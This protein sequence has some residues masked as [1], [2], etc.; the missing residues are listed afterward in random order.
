[1]VETGWPGT[2]AGGVC[3]DNTSR[4]RAMRAARPLVPPRNEGA[5]C[6][7]RWQQHARPKC[8]CANGAASEDSAV[9][10]VWRGAAQW[11]TRPHNHAAVLSCAGAA[12]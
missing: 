5:A 2:P 11:L 1:M 8:V 10:E 3:R 4:R 12:D 7:G 9:A 6:Q